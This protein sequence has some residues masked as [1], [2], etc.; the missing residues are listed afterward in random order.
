MMRIY[1]ACLIALLLTCGPAA[2]DDDYAG[3]V[4]L[5]QEF[6]E[7]APPAVH[8]GVPDYTPA[9]MQ[10]QAERLKG[11]MQR[12]AA[13]DESRWPVSQRVDYMIV[14]AEMRG[15]EFQHRV[16]RPWQRDPAF[17][18]TTN[19][20]FG[21]KIHG[22]MSIPK[23]PLSADDAAKYR[24]KLAS[25]PK[26]LEQAR[27]NLTDARGDLARLAIVQK[28]IERN[29]YDQLARD[30]ARSNPRLQREALRA[31]DATSKFLA[32]LEAT[33]AQLPAHGGI[34]REEYD[35]YLKHVLLFPYTW[36]EMRVIAQRE[37]ERSLAFL[38]IEEHRHHGA[39]MIEP[40]TTLEEF[41]R[42]RA[43][44]DAD[45]L[46]F[47]RDESIMTVPDWLVPPV[48]EGPYVLPTDRDPANKGPFA[49]PIKRHFF[50]E[51]EDRD[52]R[53][54]RAHN[55]PGHLLDQ[56]MIE[57]DTRPIRGQH[58]LYFIGG[59]RA[60]GWAFYLEEFI[61]QAGFLDDRPQT[62]EI[63]YILQTKRAARVLPEL[64]LHANL[65]TY[66]EALKSLT[67]RTPYWMGPNDSI[68]R[69]DLELYL[70]Q[71][72]YGIG[73]YIG[74]VQLEALL[75][76]R[77]AALGRDFDLKKFHDEFLAAGVIPISLIRWE[78]TGKSDQIETMR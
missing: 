31:R 37:Y 9:A 62:R 14:L 15:L 2:A 34:G 40:A 44:A 52:P 25:V 19:L 10:E 41:E 22:A 50:R 51:T 65:W 29:V 74:K 71:P 72:G 24:V 17:Y 53:P 27:S 58:L 18:S 13:I 45:L 35:W 67:S 59:T 20:G 36:E 6:R 61:Q 66:D 46:R 26:I 32:W 5:F 33:Q 11:F 8:D 63:N 55:L 42:R 30:L 48:G 4:K 76:E 75:A 7:F 77:A 47:L 43:E 69:F 12:L 38:K 70:R 78:M 60:E 1:R 3:L 28:Q 49:E 16:M 23:L 39:P 68:A 73:Y 57:R 64:M 56:L 54:L 21:P